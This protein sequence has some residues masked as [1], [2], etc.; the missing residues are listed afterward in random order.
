MVSKALLLC[1]RIQSLSIVCGFTVV[2]STFIHSFIHSPLQD[3]R[4]SLV[5]VGSKVPQ[6]SSSQVI[7]METG[8]TSL[9]PT[10]DVP[11]KVKRRKL[12]ASDVPSSSNDA[13][14]AVLLPGRRVCVVVKTALPVLSGGKAKAVLVCSWKKQSGV[15]CDSSCEVVELGSVVLSVEQVADKSLQCSK[16]C[17]FVW[18]GRVTVYQALPTHRFYKNFPCNYYSGEKMLPCTSPDEGNFQDLACV[19]TARSFIQV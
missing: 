3:V 17:L 5:A 1:I 7:S 14:G 13:L 19:L 11:P 9:D 10:P 4:L 8:S 18:K 2:F 16:D 6:E 15:P 12:S